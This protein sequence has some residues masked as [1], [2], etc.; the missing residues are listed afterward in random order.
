MGG[1]ADR[2]PNPTT[3]DGIPRVLP[4]RWI[5]AGPGG[6]GVATGAGVHEATEGWRKEAPQ[7]HGGTR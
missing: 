1:L 5:T 4:A 3:G 2:D 7:R 6:A